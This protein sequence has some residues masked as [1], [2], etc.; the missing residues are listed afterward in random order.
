MTTG[1]RRSKRSWF[2][3]KT[4][5]SNRPRRGYAGAVTPSTAFV[6]AN[7]LYPR[8]ICNWLFLLR[9]ESKGGLFHLVSSLDSLTEAIYH[10]RR[11][12]PTADGGIIARK[13]ELLKQSLD[14]LITD[15]SGRVAFPGSDPDDH[16]VHAAAVSCQAEYLITDDRGFGEI[17]PD[18]LPYEVH[19]A[20][21]FLLLVEENAPQLVDTVIMRQLTFYTQRGKSPQLAQRLRKV[22]CPGFA[23]RVEAHIKSLA[24]GRSPLDTL[25]KN[26]HPA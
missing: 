14:R 17:D 21:S 20:D 15:F 26:D 19:T 2:S 4:R 11:N 23:T 22:G 7:I 16:H 24:L 6:D 25:V 5:T 18:L 3:A 8:T 9:L 12:R 13:H 10:F 1:T